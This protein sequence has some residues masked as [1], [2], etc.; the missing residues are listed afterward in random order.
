MTAFVTQART[1]LQQFCH[2]VNGNNQEAQQTPGA[3]GAAP[4]E[5]PTIE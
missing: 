4:G 5:I 3:N 1:N 2:R